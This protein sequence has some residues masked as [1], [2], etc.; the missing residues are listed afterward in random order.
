MFKIMIVEDDAELRQLFQHVL[1]K[2]GYNVTGVS[3]GS[4]ALEWLKHD[5]FELEAK[6]FP[7]VMCHN[8][9]LKEQE[10]Y[11]YSELGTCNR[12]CNRYLAAIFLKMNKVC[13]END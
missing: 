10:N 4:K 7:F 13:L 6:L 1:I 5:Y 12:N 11:I 8:F 2:N 9:C 3:D